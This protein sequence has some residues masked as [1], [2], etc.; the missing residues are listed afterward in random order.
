[1]SAL[2]DAKTHLAKANEIST[3]EYASDLLLRLASTEAQIAL[4]DAQHET[5]RQLQMLG[6]EL[7][8]Q[9]RVVGL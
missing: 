4:A 7:R 6:D 9:N 1:M 5:N 3:S 2:D 8:R